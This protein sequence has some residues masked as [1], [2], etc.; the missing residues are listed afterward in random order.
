MASGEQSFVLMMVRKKTIVRAH[1][2]GCGDTSK[3][4]TN[5][6]LIKAPPGSLNKTNINGAQFKPN[7]QLLIRFCGEATTVAYA[8]QSRSTSSVWCQVGLLQGALRLVG[9][10]SNVDMTT[11]DTEPCLLEPFQGSG[12]GPFCM[13]ACGPQWRPAGLFMP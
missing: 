11:V 1:L 3:P 10:S 9:G 7:H 6:S 13:V 2:L 8:A 12:E 4:I 5:P